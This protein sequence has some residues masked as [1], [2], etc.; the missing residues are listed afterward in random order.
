VIDDISMY[1]L[2]TEKYDVV[3][4]DKNLETFSPKYE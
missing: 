2:R 1:I 4:L 3:L